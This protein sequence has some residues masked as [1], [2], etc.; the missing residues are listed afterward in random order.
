MQFKRLASFALLASLTAAG[1][2][3][4]TLVQGDVELDSPPYVAQIQAHTDEELTQILTRISNLY[5]SGQS[6][7]QS[8]PVALVLHGDE[9]ALFLRQN[10]QMNKDIVDLAA[11]LDA[12]NAI[13]I[14]VCETWMRYSSVPR[15]ELPAFVD[16]VPYG[17]D[18]EASLLEQGYEYF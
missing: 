6:Y 3:A 9:A 13:D 15:A 11:R 17:P 18:Q 1:V 8:Q 12:F 16:T 14:Q 2:N 10:Y 5:D 4:E 7:P